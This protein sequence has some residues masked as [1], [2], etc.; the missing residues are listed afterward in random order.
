MTELL[1]DRMLH[2]L[3]PVRHEG[4]RKFLQFMTR[5]A[6]GGETVNVRKQLIQLT[7][8]VVSRMMMGQTCSDNEDEAEQVRKLVQ[9]T[10]EL[11]G[12]FN[13]SEFIWFCKNLDLPGFRKQL[14]QVRDKFDEIKE[15]IIEEHEEARKAKKAVMIQLRIYSIFYLI[16]QKMTAPR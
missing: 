13:L 12:K 7:N 9:A 2:H 16:Y 10:A 14:K 4:I 15:K 3:L 8:N 5:K 1:G 11:T 6:N